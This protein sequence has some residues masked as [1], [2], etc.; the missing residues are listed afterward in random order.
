M[1]PGKAKSIGALIDAALR[2]ELS[3]ARALRLYKEN[4]EV[5]TLA[6]LAAANRIHHSIATRDV[7]NGSIEYRHQTLRRA[8]RRDGLRNRSEAVR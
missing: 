2:G 4:P 3:G 7:P 5:I 6:L 8:L 1:P